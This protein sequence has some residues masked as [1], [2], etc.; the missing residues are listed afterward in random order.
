[1]SFENPSEPVKDSLDE[2]PSSLPEITHSEEPSNTPEIK[3]A[4]HHVRDPKIVDDRMLNYIETHGKE[5][6]IEG[7]RDRLM[8]ILEIIDGDEKA[9]KLI[10]ETL[11]S[12]FQY[13]ERIYR[14][15]ISMQMN[16]FRLEG[17]DY[18]QATQALDQARTRAHDAL[19][20]NLT[21]CNRYLF[22]NFE[23]EI[24]TG[25]ICNIDPAVLQAGGR[26]AIGDWA[27]E[28]EYEIINNRRA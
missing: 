24:P 13:V 1:M 11:K 20:S 2:K 5:A 27:I 4:D 19:I 9:I 18:R 15:E 6:G 12:I 17:E 25:G 22:Q 21:A 28:L 8:A 26:K 14:M 16:R 3:H 10:D 7:T 23:D